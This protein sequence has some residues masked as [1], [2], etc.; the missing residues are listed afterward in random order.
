[1][2]T[3]A[4]ML[5][6]TPVSQGHTAPR[7]HFTWSHSTHLSCRNHQQSSPKPPLPHTHSQSFTD[8]PRNLLQT[9]ALR[10]YH[11]S[12]TSRPPTWTAAATASHTLVCVHTHITVTH[13]NSLTHTQNSD[14]LTYGY[15]HTEQ[16]IF[17]TDTIGPPNTQEPLIHPQ[18]LIPLHPAV[19]NTDPHSE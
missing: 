5:T 14:G 3:R 18:P 8:T 11:H 10:V 17:H 1:M 13:K 16:S 12:H 19:R 7:A 6:H 4:H 2:S 15:H 9:L